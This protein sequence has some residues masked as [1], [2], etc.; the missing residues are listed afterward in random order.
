MSGVIYWRMNVRGGSIGGGGDGF[1]GDW[2]PRGAWK[3]LVPVGRFAHNTS[4]ASCDA[5]PIYGEPVQHGKMLP[6]LDGVRQLVLDNIKQFFMCN[7]TGV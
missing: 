5:P 6:E 7:P 4:G 3:T 2:E 1:P